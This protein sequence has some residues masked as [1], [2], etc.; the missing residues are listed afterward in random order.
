MD[1][2]RL[3]QSCSRNFFASIWSY[4]VMN[5]KYKTQG[6]KIEGAKNTKTEATWMSTWPESQAATMRA[7]SEK[8]EHISTLSSVKTYT[9]RKR[10][11]R[12]LEKTVDLLPRTLLGKDADVFWPLSTDLLGAGIGDSRK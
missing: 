10:R 2:I 1:D 3:D 5:H 8:H 9:L 6:T 12:Y 4:L 7:S 11:L